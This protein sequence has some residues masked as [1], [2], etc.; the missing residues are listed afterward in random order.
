M[1]VSWL[2]LIIPDE[3][4]G[5]SNMTGTDL[6]KRT[7][8]SVPVI[9]EPPCIFHAAYRLQA[10]ALQTSLDVC[11]HTKPPAHP[12]YLFIP[13]NFVQSDTK[14][15]ELLK[16]LTKIEEIQEKKIIDRN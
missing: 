8:K 2:L 12:K 10:R 5:V 11:G 14:K 15:R 4:Q 9:F 13:G 7:H 16:N 1:C 3:I 6:Y